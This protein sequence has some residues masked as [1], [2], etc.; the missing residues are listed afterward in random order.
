LLKADLHIHSKYSMDCDT[1]LEKIIAR[2]QEVGVNCIALADHG[3]V[4]GAI[5]LQKIAPFKVI[6]AEEVLTPEGEI[7][8][9]FLKETIQSGQPLDDVINQIKAQGGLVCAQHPYDI[10]LRPGL[11]G[12]V[13]NRIADRID[14][15]EVLNARTPLAQSSRKSLA[16]AEKHNLPA[17]AGSD[18]HTIPEIGNA[19]I[20][21]PDFTDNETFLNS[22]RQGKI[23]GHLSGIFV[24]FNGF[25]RRLKSGF[26]KEAE[27]DV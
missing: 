9:M 8:G 7:M 19:Y 21:M 1:P 26:Q 17:G 2:C 27:K 5:K 6:V 10:L 15:V 25:R 11:G 14:L 3:T 4:E 23:G 20:E 18:A 13:M 22:L 24:H 12:K 16:F